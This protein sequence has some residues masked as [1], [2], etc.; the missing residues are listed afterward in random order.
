MTHDPN[1]KYDNMIPPPVRRTLLATAGLQAT[2]YTR[3]WGEL[4]RITMELRLPQKPDAI[5][6]SWNTPTT[7]A[8]MS[9]YF[10]CNR[11][12]IGERL[13]PDSA[14]MHRWLDEKIAN[15]RS[16]CG[17]AHPKEGPS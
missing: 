11:F 9:H 7:R 13:P 6:M 15:S 1:E 5:K 3:H 8:L 12:L 4:S 14:A 2:V 10:I 16:R 17:I